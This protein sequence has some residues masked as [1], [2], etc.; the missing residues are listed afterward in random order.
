MNSTDL[1]LEINCCMPRT[2]GHFVEKPKA[3]SCGH[4]V[5]SQCANEQIEIKCKRCDKINFNDMARASITKLV[6]IT[7]NKTLNETSGV[8]YSELEAIKHK[9][10]GAGIS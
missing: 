9:I 6:E 3:L 10:E 5:C 4:F 8:L 1:L 7:L 2:P